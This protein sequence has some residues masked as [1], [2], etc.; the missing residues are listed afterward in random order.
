MDRYIKQIVEIIVRKGALETFIYALKILLDKLTSLFKITFLKLRGY[1]INYS[2]LL[3]GNNFFFQSTKHAVNISEHTIIGKN[4]RIS[5]GGN[6]KVFIAENVLIDDSTFIMAHEKIEIG[7]NTKIAA[8]SFITDF[9]HK[10][11]DV[12]L[13]VVKQE[14]VTKPV[15]IGRNVWIGTHTVIL[16]GVTIGDRVVIGAGSIVTKDIPANSVAV[17]N[18]ARVIKHI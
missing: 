18:P 5:G 11:Q 10:Y 13:S 7:K 15:K 12:N 1:N 6:G 8:F 2:V 9:N 3:K 17:G 14:Y 4:T 16:P